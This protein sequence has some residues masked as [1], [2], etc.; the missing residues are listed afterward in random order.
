MIMERSLNFYK[1]R[2]G[3]TRKLGLGRELNIDRDEE[4]QDD[5]A[6]VLRDSWA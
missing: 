4:R 6:R 5:G 3:E 2:I 1:N